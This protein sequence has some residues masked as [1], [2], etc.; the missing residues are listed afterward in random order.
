MAANMDGQEDEPSITAGATK[1]AFR[2]MR[3]DCKC[4]HRSFDSVVRKNANDFAQ[5]DKV[6]WVFRASGGWW[7]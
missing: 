3:K 1:S 7:C 4:N 5:N 2:W 6:W